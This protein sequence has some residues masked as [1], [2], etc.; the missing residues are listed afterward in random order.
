MSPIRHQQPSTPFAMTTSSRGAWI[1][2]LFSGFLLLLSPVTASPAGGSTVAKQFN[3]NVNGKD[4]SE[5]WYNC[6]MYVTQA[7]PAPWMSDLHNSPQNL[8]ANCEYPEYLQAMGMC[9]VSQCTNSWDVQYA[10]EFGAVI[11]KKAGVKTAIPIDPSY[12]ATAGG[13]YATAT[14]TMDMPVLASSAQQRSMFRM[15]TA[16]L[17]VLGGALQEHLSAGGLTSVRLVHEYLQRIEDD[18]EKGLELHAVVE[19]ESRAKLRA[20]AQ[21]FDSLRENGPL[22]RSPPLGQGLE[23]YGNRIGWVYFEA[24]TKAPYEEKVRLTYSHLLRAGP[25]A[26]TINK[27]RAGGAIILGKTYLPGYRSDGGDQQ[28]SS[29]RPCKSAYGEH[30]SASFGGAVAVS[31]GF[32]AAAIAG[33]STAAVIIPAARNACF[34]IRPTPGLGPFH[35]TRDS[36][37]VAKSAHDLAILLTALAATDPTDPTDPWHRYFVAPTSMVGQPVPNGKEKVEISENPKYTGT[38]FAN[39][40]GK[41]LGILPK[42]IFAAESWGDLIINGSVERVFDDFDRAILRIKEL[43]A[44][45]HDIIDTSSLTTMKGTEN[46][47]RWTEHKLM[48]IASRTTPRSIEGARLKHLFRKLH[49]GQTREMPI[50]DTDIAKFLNKEPNLEHTPADGCEW[51]CDSRTILSGLVEHLLEK[52]GL[53]VM[54]EKHGLHA[55]VAPAN[56]AIT[57]WAALDGCPIATAPLGTDDKGNPHGIC[58]IG[59]R[60]SESTLIALL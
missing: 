41:R 46:F 19:L 30:H 14:W 38:P 52:P 53:E 40:G 51:R 50:G 20:T 55:L 8:Q 23:E 24:S 43:G 10:R 47:E 11:C 37:P 39:F 35:E 27:L 6:H 2:S 15:R 57:R 54:L 29:C 45:I 26:K 7:L 3:L 5:C 49:K 16:V 18:N 59:R 28:D 31:V 25:Q 42:G 12:T 13:F 32:A 1:L 9:L 21:H 33:N 4:V 58:F 17:A 60:M 48:K 36:G 56:Y 34:A 22:A 44:E